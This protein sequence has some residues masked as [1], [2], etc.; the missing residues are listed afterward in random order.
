MK[1]NGHSLIKAINTWAVGVIPYLAPFLEWNKDELEALDR[2]T[3]KLMTMQKAL[4]PKSNV[5]RLYLPKKEGGRG[6][7]S[8]E[9]ATRT[10]M[11]ELQKCI[12]ESEEKLISAARKLEQVSESAKELK[13]RRAKKC[14]RNWIDKVMHGQFLRQTEAVAAKDTWAWLNRG[15]SRGKQKHSS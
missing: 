4:H 12:Q 10:A 13:S 3:R 1:L 15:G 14:R 2:R 6:H 7:S 8:I 5:D 9:D 11:L